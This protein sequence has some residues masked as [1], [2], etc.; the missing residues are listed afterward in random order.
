MNNKFGLR[1]IGLVK[2]YPK[3]DMSEKSTEW[4]LNEKKRLEK[5]LEEKTE[6]SQSPKR[7]S[8]MYRIGSINSELFSRR[9]QKK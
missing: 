5:S 3:T 7:I 9:N 4:L 1:G 2:C 6:S 8:T